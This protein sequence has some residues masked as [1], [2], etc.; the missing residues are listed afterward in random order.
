[1]EPTKTIN[2]KENISSNMY[3]IQGIQRPVNLVANQLKLVSANQE[4]I[5]MTHPGM[6]NEPPPEQKAMLQQQETE[7]T[8]FIMEFL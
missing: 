1:M 6:N 7:D 4:T 8:L 3:N 2:K 5:M